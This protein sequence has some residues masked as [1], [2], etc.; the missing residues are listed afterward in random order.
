MGP[1]Y[2]YINVEGYED[3]LVQSFAP[4]QATEEYCFPLTKLPGCPSSVWQ[5]LKSFYDPNQD[6]EDISGFDDGNSVI[7]S[8]INEHFSYFK[9]I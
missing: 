9:I 8:L 6:Y 5:E 2:Q 1:E 3:C 4:G 7:H